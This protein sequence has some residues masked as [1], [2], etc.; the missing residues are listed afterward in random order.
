MG[1]PSAAAK[2]EPAW[3]ARSPVIGSVRQPNGLVRTQLP[4]GSGNTSRV[5]SGT[6][7]VG[8]PPPPPEVM[9]RVRAARMASATGW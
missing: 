4:S 1:V 5:V 3:K 7:A 9:G 8:S 2:S 6:T